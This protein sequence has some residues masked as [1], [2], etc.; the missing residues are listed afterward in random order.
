MGSLDLGAGHFS[1]AV[2]KGWCFSK[3][4]WDNVVSVGNCFYHDVFTAK[5]PPT[6]TG[7]AQVK[8][9]VVPR[10]HWKPL[11]HTREPCE[12]KH[13]EQACW[14]GSPDPAETLSEKGSV[15]AAYFPKSRSSNGMKAVQA[16]R[17]RCTSVYL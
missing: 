8:R 1:G 15:R 4:Q 6:V 11:S 14:C 10:S 16:G 5:T 12:A 2:G 3:Q 9:P 13:S 17:G 7:V